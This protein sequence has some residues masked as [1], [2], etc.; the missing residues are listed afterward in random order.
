MRTLIPIGGNIDKKE[1]L[2]LIEFVKRAGGRKAKIIIFPQASSLKD[3][4]KKYT[5][6]FNTLGAGSVESL[7]FSKRAE[8]NQ[9]RFLESIRKASGVFICGGNQMRIPILISGTP[10]EQELIKAYQRGC[11]ISGTSAGA[12]VLS[13]TMIAYGK[14]GST[15]REGIAQFFPGIGFTDKFI[16]DQ[17]FRQ[18]DR[19]GRLIYAISIC[20]G[21]LGVGVDENTAAIIENES[22]ITVAGSGAVTI[23]D[24]NQITATDAADIQNQNP[25]AVS[26]LIVHVLTHGCVYH[27]STNKVSIP[28]KQSLS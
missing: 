13:K 11:V 12:A 8:V 9:P 3:T 22:S 26:N 19:L 21:A 7:E 28:K 1:P 14:S 16:F 15:P 10:I 4:G 24:G 5:A 27:G 20:P 6:L 25:I 18:R 17:H 2:A 23:V